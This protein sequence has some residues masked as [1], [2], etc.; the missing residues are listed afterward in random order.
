MSA[1]DVVD[2]GGGGSIY[3]F[4][5]RGHSGEGAR[6]CGVGRTEE[7][8]AVKGQGAGRTCMETVAQSR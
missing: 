1:E 2:P 6:G 5:K 3:I 8:R 7:Q 4:I